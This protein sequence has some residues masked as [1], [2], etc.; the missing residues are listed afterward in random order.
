MNL[1]NKENNTMI[2]ARIVYKQD[3][4]GNTKPT[5]TRPFNMYADIARFFRAN[6]ATVLKVVDR[7]G[8]RL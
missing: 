5:L 7:Q 3:I 8:V 4:H 1:V 6:R 2:V